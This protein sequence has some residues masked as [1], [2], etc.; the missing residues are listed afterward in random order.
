MTSARAEPGAERGRFRVGTGLDPGYDVRMLAPDRL[1]GGNVIDGRFVVEHEFAAGG[2]GRI[3]RGLDRHTGSP[4]AIKVVYETEAQVLARFAREASILAE[5][6]HPG[7][8]QYVAH[9]Y[10]PGGALYL[11]MEWLEGETLAMHLSN[12]P[13]ADPN[14]TQLARPDS[15]TGRKPD[16]ARLPLDQVLLLARRVASSLAAIHRRGI[17]HR[18]LKP[19]NFVLVGGEI[20]RVKLIDFGLARGAAA[21]SVTYDGYLVGTPRYMSPEQARGAEVGPPADIWALGCVLYQ[22]LTGR[23]AFGEADALVAQARAA[24][25]DPVPASVLR[26]DTPLALDRIL[27]SMLIKSPEA[28]LSS[29]DELARALAKVCLEPGDDDETLAE[30]RDSSIRRSAGMVAESRV[31]SLLAATGDGAALEALRRAAAEHGCRVEAWA[32]APHVVFVTR[33]GV[34]SPREE[35]ARA[36]H[37]AL[38]LT[39]AADAVAMAIVTGHDQGGAPSAATDL[40]ERAEATLLLTAPGAI[41]LDRATAD[42]LEGRFEL[43]ADDSS[44]LLEGKKPAEDIRT[45][46]GRPSRWVGR[47]RE[48]SLLEDTFEECQEDSRARAVIVTGDAGM[49]KSRL[50]HEFLRRLESDGHEAQI[51]RG[52]GDSL[53]AG[54]PFVM[55]APALRRSAGILDGEPTSEARDKL[56]ARLRQVIPES[57][58]SRV[59]TFLGELIDVPCGGAESEPLRAARASPMLLADLMRDAFVAWLAAE[60]RRGPVLFVLED[61]HWGDLPSVKLLDAALQA[62]ADQPFMVLALARPE[63]HTAFPSLWER[64]AVDEVRLHPLSRK[65]CEA[66]V[67]DALGQ[68]ARESLVERLVARSEGNA[69]YLEELIRHAAEADPGSRLP[70]SVLGTVQARLAPLDAGARR[71]LRAASVFGEVFWEGGVTALIGDSGEAFGAGEW[72]GELC[73]QELISRRTSSRL[74]DEREYEF[75]HALVRD[76]IYGMIGD[77]DRTAAHLVAGEWL[78]AAG[79]R[80][81]LVLAA[82][83]ERGGDVSRAVAKYRTAAEHALAAGDF[84]AAA[85]RAGRALKIGAQ[86]ASRGALL[87]IQAM[88]ASWRSRHADAAA[89]GLEALDALPEASRDWFSAAST[90]LVASARL[91]DRETFDRL[92]V[93]AELVDPAPGAGPAQ[94]VCLCRAV[95][96][97]AQAGRMTEADQILTRIAT[98][99]S[100]GAELDAYTRAQIHDAR[101]GRA[102]CVGDAKTALEQMRSAVEAFDSVGDEHNVMLGKASMAWVISELGDADAAAAV[103]RQTLSACERGGVKLGATLSKTLLGAILSRDTGGCAEARARLREGISDYEAVGSRTYAGWGYGFLAQCELTAGN[104]D[105]AREH[106]AIAVQMVHGRP[107]FEAWALALHS[108][109]LLRLGDAERAAERA[110]AAMAIYNTQGGIAG[111]AALPPLA[112]AEALLAAGRRDEAERAIAYARDELRRRTADLEGTP[113]KAKYLALPDPAH[114]LE[115]AAR[116]LETA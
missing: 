90:A 93:R 22:C 25:D 69:F 95:F 115:L 57:E 92:F 80:D 28:R 32:N 21:E 74:P 49:G 82:H 63:V 17:V 38:E 43:G 3:Y 33:D 111:N 61:L 88:A 56:L 27:Q 37:A 76:A 53:S 71:I 36:A 29:G 62:L 102:F 15:S 9:G 42:L 101:G 78:E 98:L 83:A 85:Q 18:D 34:D 16:G 5:I 114:T 23:A 30:A 106:A 70:E 75:R 99:E 55:V 6:Q 11:V 48:L 77:E 14:R 103:A 96:Q 46:L 40:A 100:R 2:M 116:W 110:A 39:G 41:R 89:H 20:A 54:S 72:L 50:L 65:A 4:V 10:S 12:Q 47:R 44:D 60:C 113:W 84:A 64:R 86:G 45:L 73:R 105:A 31:R 7:I 97:L 108:R 8:V 112:H 81:A 94:L 79:E 51:L 109:A 67:R 1:Q 13:A 59:A 24:V 107:G 52:R 26:P 87:V 35:A 58:R 68:S 91:G 66:L 104:P 19:G